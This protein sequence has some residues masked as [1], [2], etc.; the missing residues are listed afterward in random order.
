MKCII[1]AIT[2][3]E[4]YGRQKQI[5]PFFQFESFARCWRC[6]AFG[7]YP[8]IFFQTSGSSFPP[9]RKKCISSRTGLYWQTAV[10]C[11]LLSQCHCLSC[12]FFIC[13][14]NA[15]VEIFYHSFLAPRVVTY[16][17]WTFLSILYLVKQ[18]NLGKCT[19]ISIIKTKIDSFQT[20][21]TEWRT[22][23]M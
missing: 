14:S 5:N 6:G 11:S 3:I 13:E 2:M 1:P 17:A 7:C 16:K 10:C 22:D 8:L 15:T 19:I 4:E 9:K 20:L 18:S 21:W 23:Q 12:N